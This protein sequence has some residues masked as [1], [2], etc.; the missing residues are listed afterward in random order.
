MKRSFIF[1]IVFFLVI[2]N[3]VFIGT[4]MWYKTKLDNQE[5]KVYSFQGENTDIR[6]TEGLIILFPNRHIVIG[7]N[8][9][10]IGSKEEQIKSYSQNI[11]LD[12]E[13][14]KYLVLSKA[15]SNG[16]DNKG[17]SLSGELLLNKS[18]GE[19]SSQQ[20]FNEEQLGIIKNNLYFNLQYSTV[21]GKIE[22]SIIM[23]NV[24][25][26]NMRENK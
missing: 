14:D 26:F 8:I 18:I 2:T 19:I 25:E 16:W 21:D 9:Q 6:V 10:Y 17:T 11:Y 24:E 20:L 5:F 23:L 13:G 4:T 15:V 3:I 22:N 7:G 12:K 1:W